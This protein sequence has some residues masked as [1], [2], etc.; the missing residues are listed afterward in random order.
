MRLRTPCLLLCL[1]PLI[2]SSCGSDLP[3]AVLAMEDHIPE[4]VD[5]NQHI[6]PILSDRCWSCHGPDAEARTASLRLDTEEGA[7][8]SLASGAGHAFV[9]GRPGKS[10]ALARMVSTDPETVMPPPESKMSLTAREIALVNRWIEQGA[11]WKDHWAFL[12]I[13]AH[14]V[15]D[16]PAGYPAENA[17]D[18]FINERLRQEGLTANPRADPERLLRRVYLDLTGLPPSPEVMDRWLAEPSDAAYRQLVEELLTSEAHAERLAMDW[19]DVARY[20]DSHGLH[21]DGW[22]MAWP[23]R[24]WVIEAFQRNLPYDQFITQQI[25]GDLLPEPSRGSLVASAFNRMHPMT[26]EGGVI[27][28]E[29][30]LG[31]VA[32]RVNT[33]ATGMLGLTMDCSRCHDHKFDPISQKEYYGFSAFFN[34]FRELGMTGDDG[35]FGPYLLLTDEVQDNILAAYEQ[36]LGILRQDKGSVTVSDQELEAFLRNAGPQ[37]VRADH[38]FTFDRIASDGQGHRIDRHAWATEE[39]TFPTVPGRGRVAQF[40]HPYDDIYLDEGIAGIQSHDPLSVSLMIR[41]TKRDS[42]LM[43]TLLGNAGGKNEAWQGTEWYLDDENYLHLRL[44]RTMPDDLLHVVSRDSIKVNTWTQV[45]FTYDGS[46]EAIGVQLYLNGRA[47]EQET[48]VDNLRGAIYP[49]NH[50]AWR[51]VSSRKTRLG[52]A[53]RAFTGENGIFLGQMDDLRIF[54]R[55]LTQLEMAQQ[56]NAPP[57]ISRDVATEHL[58]RTAPRYRETMEKF[59]KIQGERLALLDST[60]RLMISE[61]MNRPRTTFVLDRGAYDAPL[62]PVQPQTPA[63]IL[64]YSEDLPPNRLG[65]ARWIFDDRNPL[66]ARVAVNRYWQLIFGQGI[67]KTPHDFGSQGALPSH[68]HLLDYLAVQF[69]DNGWNVRDLLRMMVLSDTYRRESHAEREQREAD[70][71]NVLLARGPSVRL[72]AEIIRDNALAAAG[73]LHREVGGPSVKPYQPAGLWIQSNNFSRMLL[74]YEADTG[75]KLYRRSMYTFIKRTAPPPFLINF[76]ASGRDVCTVKRSTTNTPL[77]ALNLLNDPQF[78]EAARVLAQRVQHEKSGPD[79]QLAHAFRLVAGR[80]PAPE[81]TEILKRLYVEELAR[82]AEHPAL[83]DSL[84]LVGEYPVPEELDRSTTAALTSVSNM[85]FSFDEAYVK[86]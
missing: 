8:A 16:N 29:F 44:I 69:R 12:P 53:Y 28:E 64:P 20:A 42:S 33:V 85:L 50:E 79:Q 9:S 58:L 45:G 51:N 35:N 13:E 32:D 31:Y 3:P 57:P 36:Q 23:Y 84:L 25:A 80:R 21:A 46:G 1:L 82:Y 18:H 71:E 22:R 48:L 56:V 43:Q 17:L 10:V 86:R 6:R 66:T 26:A 59:R 40:D 14:E 49:V 5:F 81:E 74:T 2:F 83:A 39:T 4:T 68:P 19:L 52:Q 67:V 75:N 41:T 47:V 34:N 76:D 27:A 24:D 73:L 61:D 70:P 30:R 63:S 55:P 15:P 62:E 37:P 38:T 72:P 7:F 77:Q 78:V 54:K 11:I 65:L 60:P